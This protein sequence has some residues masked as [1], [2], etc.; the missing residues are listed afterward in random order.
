MIYLPRFILLLHFFLLDI[1]VAHA[2]ESF[3]VEIKTEELTKLP[4]RFYVTAVTDNRKDTL[5]NGFAL[6][7]KKKVNIDFPGGLKNQMQEYFINSLP[8]P[9]TSLLPVTISIKKLVLTERVTSK[10]NIAKTDVTIQFLRSYNDELTQLLELSTWMEQGALKDASKLQE[11]NI[12]DIMKRML[13]QFDKLLIDHSADPLLAPKIE[14]RVINP[15]DDKL[16]DDTIFWS[17]DRKLV[18]D[19]F[20]G[21]P[22][23]EIYAA[24]SN[25]AF[26]QGIEPTVENADLIVI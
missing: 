26:G 4:S 25:C 1:F 13:Q 23:D 22:G 10:G 17:T 8:A 6:I 16:L 11:K 21:V 24:Q 9:D 18:W 15:P 14:F 12:R 19:D 5:N 7:N 20:H 3:P 2:Q